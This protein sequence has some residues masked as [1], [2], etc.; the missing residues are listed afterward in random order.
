M[1]NKSG[2]CCSTSVVYSYPFSVRLLKAIKVPLFLLYLF[3]IFI[4]FLQRLTKVNFII[5]LVSYIPVAFS[6]YEAYSVLL[7]REYAHSQGCMNDKRKTFV[8]KFSN[9]QNHPEYLIKIPGSDVKSSRRSPTGPSSCRGHGPPVAPGLSSILVHRCPP[10]RWVFQRHREISSM[11]FVIAHG[12]PRAL[13][14]RYWR[15]PPRSP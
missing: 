15:R 9:A 8:K 5:Q 2:F 13:N 12:A 10:Y 1:R 14:K 3:R 6:S 11:G 4:L 7:F